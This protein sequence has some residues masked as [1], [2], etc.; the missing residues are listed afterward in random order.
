MRE[1]DGYYSI[2]AVNAQHDQMMKEF[3]VLGEEIE[4]LKAKNKQLEEEKSKLIEII[5][6]YI[7]RK[8][9]PAICTEKIQVFEDRKEYDEILKFIWE[10]EDTKTD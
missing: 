3:G 5:N 6:R 7:L 8:M 9:Y 4:D 1:I 2:D 10:I